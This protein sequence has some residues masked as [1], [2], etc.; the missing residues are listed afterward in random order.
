[1]KGL[2]KIK[3]TKKAYSGIKPESCFVEKLEY[4]GIVL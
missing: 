4:T 3:I 1:M 2:V